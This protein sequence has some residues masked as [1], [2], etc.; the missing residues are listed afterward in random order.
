[1]DTFD[2]DQMLDQVMQAFSNKGSE[3]EAQTEAPNDSDDTA[4]EMA[5]FVM[6]M[7]DDMDK[8][9]SGTDDRSKAILFLI[10]TLIKSMDEDSIAEAIYILG[11]AYEQGKYNIKKD[12]KK[13]LRAYGFMAQA[14]DVRALERMEVMFRTGDGVAQDDEMADTIK[15]IKIKQCGEPPE[16]QAENDVVV[17]GAALLSWGN[18]KVFCSVGEDGQP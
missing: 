11:T 13:A 15:A 7:M 6:V 18:S 14:G 12:Y 9:F 8:A 10:S 5:D 1:M 3:T 16:P 17:Q 4:S 2:K